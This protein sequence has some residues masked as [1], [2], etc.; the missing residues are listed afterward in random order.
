[1]LAEMD[2]FTE[3]APVLRRTG[4]TTEDEASKAQTANMVEVTD[5]LR[6]QL[7]ERTQLE[8]KASEA[9]Y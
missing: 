8:L 3:E 4:I 2:N 1:M 5:N 9:F 7:D 6:I